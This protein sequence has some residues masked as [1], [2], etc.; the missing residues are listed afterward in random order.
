MFIRA[1]KDI[2]LATHSIPK[3]GQVDLAAEVATKLVRDGVAEVVDTE[4]A[5]RNIT[6]VEKRTGKDESNA[7]SGDASESPAAESRT[8]KKASRT[9]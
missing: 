7:E 9:K 6:G 3:G 2:E 4:T 5:I 1:K 8:S